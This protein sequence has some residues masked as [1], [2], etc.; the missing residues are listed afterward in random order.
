MALLPIS[1]IWNLNILKATKF[2]AYML[3]LIGATSS[4]VSLIRFAFVE[5][6][7]PDVLFFKNTG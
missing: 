7:E 4:I 6:L 1:T 3:M 2:W 5:S